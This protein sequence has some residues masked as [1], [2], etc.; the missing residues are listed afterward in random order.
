MNEV[1]YFTRAIIY[2]RGMFIK[3]AT[4]KYILDV[5]FIRIVSEASNIK[6]FTVVIVA[7]L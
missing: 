7:V 5:R 2:E 4:G 6:L 1:A 3:S